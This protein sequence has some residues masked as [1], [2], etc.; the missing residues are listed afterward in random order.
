MTII[1]NGKLDGEIVLEPEYG[2]FC[3]VR[4]KFR[5][6]SPSTKIIFPVEEIEQMI[7]LLNTLKKIREE[8]I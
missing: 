8:E 7:E 1:R 3:I 5:E 2:Y 6:M 4:R